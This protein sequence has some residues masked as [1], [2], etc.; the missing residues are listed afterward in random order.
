MKFI[1]GIMA[2]YVVGILIAPM[3]GR[4]L[5]HQLLARADEQARAKAREI[6]AEAGE[7]AY[8]KI[9]NSVS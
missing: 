3:S 7:K 2:G 1:V 5:R 4:E 9:V 8:Q 6:G